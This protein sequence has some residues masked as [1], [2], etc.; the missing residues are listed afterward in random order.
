VSAPSK[1][2]LW[3]GRVL[4]ALPSLALIM[5]G[6]MKLSHAPPVV[7]GFT[8]FG[9][10]L[11]ALTPIGILELA[12]V[13]LYLVPRTSVLGAILVTAY[14]GGAT[15]THVRVGEPFIA[16]VVLGIFVWL[17]LYLRD[18]RLRALVP[19]RSAP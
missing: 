5:S 8:K 9:F 15:V 11:G 3:G 2:M 14:L 12:C 18:E 1:G 10:S 6:G 4:S 7:E 19:L 17:G 16:P 13:V